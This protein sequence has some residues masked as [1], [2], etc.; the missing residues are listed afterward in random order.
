MNIPQI[1]FATNNSKKVVEVKEI[2]GCDIKTPKELDIDPEVVE[3]GETFQANAV[4]KAVEI[5]MRCKDKVPD[6]YIVFS[7]DSGLEIDYLNKAPGV[8][9]ARY[10]GEDTPY[11]VKNA[12]I[13]EMLKAVPDHQRSAR[14]VCVIAA[15]LWD[16]GQMGTQNLKVITTQATI[17]G[18]IA[19]EIKGKNGFGYD[20]IF[21]VPEYKMT[22]AEMPSDLKNRISHRGKALKRMKLEL[23]SKSGLSEE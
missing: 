2:L 12:R 23:G 5:F 14:F 13:L 8:L 18:F 19:H 4:K 17:E 7:D 3:D 11:S 15:V 6:P 22:T 9:S 20:P 21:Y 16:E 10:M 1:I